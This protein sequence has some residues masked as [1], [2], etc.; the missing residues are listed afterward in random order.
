MPV[1]I[2]PAPVDPYAGRMATEARRRRLAQIDRQ[3]D[4][5]RPLRDPWRELEAA[6]REHEQT[7]LVGHRQRL[8]NAEFELVRLERRGRHR[9]TPADTDRYVQLCRLRDR[10]REWLSAY[11]ESASFGD[12]DRRAE[13]FIG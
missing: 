13:S 8:E 7:L 6:D 3:L 4:I 5:R 9:W 12:R 1:G 11:E 10:S 2:H